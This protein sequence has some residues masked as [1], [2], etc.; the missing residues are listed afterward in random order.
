MG[1][2]QIAVAAKDGEEKVIA[3]WRKHN[4]LQGWMENLYRSQ[5]GMEVFN[6]QPVNLTLDNIN[7]LEKT[8]RKAE[9]PKTE[10]FFFGSDSY[11]FD[12]NYYASKDLEFIA[13]AKEAIADG[14]AV[15]YNCWW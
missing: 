12:M 3:D 5:G 4:R 10:G 11:E 6:C 8:V 1:L 14:W 13:Q 7:S 2:D 15:T 9:L